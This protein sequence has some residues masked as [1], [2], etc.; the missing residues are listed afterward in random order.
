MK[1][2][3]SKRILKFDNNLQEN[4]EFFDALAEKGQILDEVDQEIRAKEIE[5]AKVDEMVSFYH[6]NIER[7]KTTLEQLEHERAR[8][9]EDING[10]RT[11]LAL[12]ISEHADL[13]MKHDE[14]RQRVDD[15]AEYQKKERQLMDQ[16]HTSYKETRDD[17][18]QTI[19]TLQNKRAELIE[20][21]S[22]I[23]DEQ[24]TLEED[25]SA[26]KRFKEEKK[27]LLDD[28]KRLQK[29]VATLRG[30]LSIYK[31]RLANGKKGKRVN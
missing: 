4:E 6:Q 23:R 2:T 17:I 27:K 30:D 14:L 29:E 21:L 15:L 8:L 18:L 16:A 22:S 11:Q 7:E 28:Q 12:L 24:S 20:S 13:A 31:Q 9:R 5:K 1:K 3:Y 25:K 10:K 19:E 26:L